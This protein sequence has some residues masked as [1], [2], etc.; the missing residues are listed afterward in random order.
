MKFPDK[1]RIER[2]EDYHTNYIGRYENG[3]QFWGY[4]TFVQNPFQEGENWEKYR[5]E[6][7]V[8]YLFD[9]AEILKI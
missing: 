3:N 9:K 7:A 1:I 5:E 8:L 2:M 6:F 4:A